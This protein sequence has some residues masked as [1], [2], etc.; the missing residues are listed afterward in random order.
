V[1]VKKKRPIKYEPPSD[2][3]L[4]E[5]VQQVSHNLSEQVSPSYARHEIVRGLAD[6]LA[7]LAT[8]EANQRNRNR[9]FDEGKE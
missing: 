1:I 3:T 2:D 9:L 5:F 7:T 4:F 8:I 6:F